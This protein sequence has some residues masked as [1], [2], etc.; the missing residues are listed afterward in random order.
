MPKPP[1]ANDP[2]NIQF[3]SGTT[4]QPKAATLSHFNTLN[5]AYLIGNHC[6]YTSIDNIAI[7]VPFYHCFG[8]IMGSLAAITR[9]A[10]ITIICEGFDP[11]K[12]L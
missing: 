2:V 8:M 12:S 10:S 5:N 1:S 7:P 4:G 3:T 11:K 6:K 9:G